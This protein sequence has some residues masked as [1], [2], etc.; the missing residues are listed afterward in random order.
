MQRGA[1]QY[2]AGKRCFVT[3]AASGIGRATALRL[4]AQ[5]A[6]LYL[7]D[8]DRDGLAQTVC[9]ARALGAQVPEHRVL[10]VSD[11]QDVAAFAADI[12]ARH[13]SMDVVL[14][15]PVCRP[16]APL[17]SS[18]TISGAGWSRSISWAQSTSSRPW[19]H[20]WSPPVGAGTWSMCPRR[21]GWLA[22]RGMRPIALAST[23]CGDFLR[24]CASIWPGT[25]SGCRSWCLAPSRPR[26]S[27]RS[28][29]P[30][31]IATT[32]GSTAGSNGSVVTP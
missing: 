19:S 15:T 30:E 14:N 8:R 12:H 17:T 22:C 5:G 23:G 28:R 18:R 21:P 20:R 11:Y 2:F 24:C 4:A 9:D 10:D 1:G 25:A 16:G 27:I 29:S 13:P 26:W 6:E 31:W 7:T 3:G 32:R